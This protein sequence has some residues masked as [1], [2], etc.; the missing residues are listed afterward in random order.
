M[1]DGATAAPVWERSLGSPVD[2]APTAADVDSDGKWEILVATRAGRLH[3]L[4]AATGA[5]VPRTP[6]ALGGSI[7]APVVAVSVPRW[8]DRVV[9]AVAAGRAGSG[10]LILLDPLERCAD[11]A[12]VG[13][14]A[15]SAVLAGD[16]T[17]SGAGGFVDLVL[18]T[19]AGSVLAF[20]TDLPAGAWGASGRAVSEALPTGARMQHQ[21]SLGGVSITEES[22]APRDVSSRSI[23]VEADVARGGGAPYRVTVALEEVPRSLLPKE[24]LTT[25]GGGVETRLDAPGR[26]AVDLPVPLR[27]PVSGTVVVRVVDGAGHVWEDRFSLSFHSH[28]PRMLRWLLAGPLL[29][30]GVLVGLGV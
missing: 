17:G 24:T 10:G 29:L 13:E 27:G 16:L 26:V 15:T 9:L 12:F 1:F 25:S 4:R 19:E 20:E 14:G 23:R 3:A 8:G 30:F 7:A 6:W 11:V 18:S 28:F 22:R 21:G 2:A 5:D